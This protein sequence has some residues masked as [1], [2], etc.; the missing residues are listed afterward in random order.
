M[1]D[2]FLFSIAGKKSN[3]VIDGLLDDL[4]SKD[5]IPEQEKKVLRHTKK[6]SAEGNYPSSSYYLTYWAQPAFT[7]NSLAEIV[8]Y[9]KQMHDYYHASKLQSEILKAINKSETYSDLKLAV[10]NILNEDDTVSSDELDFEGYTY[11]ESCDTPHGTGLESCVQEFDALTNGF[12]P[13]T[14]GVIGGFTSHGKSTYT[15]SFIFKNIRQGRKGCLLSIEMPPKLVWLQ[16]ESRYMYEVKGLSLTQQELTQHKL[17]KDVEDKVK[18]YEE[19][20]KRDIMD[21]L[22]IIDESYIS[23]PMMMDYKAFSRFMKKV[24]AKLGC[25]DFLCV[26]HVGQF[27]QMWKESGNPIIKQLQSFTKTYQNTESINPFTLLAVQCNREGEKRARKRGGVYDIQ[28]ISELNEVE[29][30]ATYILFIYADDNM[31]IV[32]ECKMTLHK[33]RLGATLTEPV[34]TTFNPAVCTVGSSVE[35]VTISDDDFNSLGDF[36]FGDDEF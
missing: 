5:Y 20:F 4:L 27:E 14:V 11:G 25:L 7:Y 36:S 22:V 17:P 6:V 26:D 1:I 18:E 15:L 35:K 13:G 10:E 31:K 16:L 21:N 30:T 34:T 3:N 8:S 23:L 28:A 33:H 24:E 29:K 32:Q 19:D 9:V 12:Q 2:V